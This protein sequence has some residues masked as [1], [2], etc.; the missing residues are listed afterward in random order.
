MTNPRLGTVNNLTPASSSSPAGTYD[1]D[2]IEFPGGLWPSGQ[3]TFAFGTEPNKITG[4][5]KVVQIFLK[6]F[7]SP[8]GSDILNP[9]YGTQLALDLTNSCPNFDN[10]TQALQVV[11]TAVMDAEGQVIS[12]TSASPPESQLTSVALV[13]V[14]AS[15]GGLKITLYLETGAGVGAQIAIPQPQLNLSLAR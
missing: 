13:G 14:V 8:L 1:L 7:L 2:I 12:L 3:L 5:Q 15:Q 6:C 4:L 10:S 11:Q 9:S